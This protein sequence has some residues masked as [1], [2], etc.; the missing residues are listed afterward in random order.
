MKGYIFIAS[1]KES[2]LAAVREGGFSVKLSFGAIKDEAKKTRD[3]TS[4]DLAPGA[5]GTRNLK[6]FKILFSSLADFVGVA[7]G[8]VVFFFTGRNLFGV[9][10]VIGTPKAG[11][12]LNYPSA[13]AWPP[14]LKVPAKEALET[15]THPFGR[16]V[17]A[18][19]P[20]GQWFEEGLDIDDALGASGAEIAQ[21][22]RLMKGRSFHQLGHEETLWLAGLIIRRL[23]ATGKELSLSQDD[24]KR[25]RTLHL[26]IGNALLEPMQV[27]DVVGAGSLDLLEKNGR[28]KNE[29]VLHGLLLE[30]IRSPSKQN[31]GLVGAP[32][33]HL[34]LLDCF[35][36]Y[37]GSPA[38]QS[39]WAD[40]I[41]VLA[42]F[43]RRPLNE[44]LHAVAPSFF[45][46]YEVKRDARAGAVEPEELV[47]QGLKY[48]DF[49]VKRH[50]AGDYDPVRLTIVLAKPKSSIEREFQEAVRKEIEKNAIR[51]FTIGTRD[52][53]ARPNREWKA[54]RLLLYSW[55][56]GANQ[57]R[58][59][60][61]VG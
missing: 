47:T 1:D 59:E 3:V 45:D 58:L 48:V 56:A 40:R 50:T 7:A 31:A 34:D 30:Q 21:A 52:T 49:I 8:D 42:C 53:S 20:I 9:G 61:P 38:K 19:E 32:F 41:D 2:I 26:K 5:K 37:W 23:G 35:H 4:A 24:L 15:G 6:L 25:A 14:P 29:S 12:F 17:V 10:R 46:V 33:T 57:L 18:F 28:I 11:S 44:R 22:L 51:R 60:M 13:L 55:D 43:G 54:A 27:S 16:V 36:E 39:Q